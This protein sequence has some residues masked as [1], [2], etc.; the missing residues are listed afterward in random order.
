MTAIIL[1]FLSI[2]KERL[3]LVIVGCWGYLP[4]GGSGAMIVIPGLDGRL[5]SG[6]L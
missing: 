2:K 1:A 5:R 6:R 3:A 4:H